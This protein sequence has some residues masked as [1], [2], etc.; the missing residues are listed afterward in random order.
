MADEEAALNLL[1]EGESNRAVANHQ[2]N[3][4]STRGHAIFTIYVQI[5]SRVESS[6]KV[7]ISAAVS[8]SDLSSRDATSMM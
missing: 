4:N 1:F 5:R 8:A 2:L 3:R 7:C 6:D